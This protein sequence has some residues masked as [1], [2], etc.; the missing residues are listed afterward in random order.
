M[1]T[2][3]SPLVSCFGLAPTT[4]SPSCYSPTCASSVSIS[5]TTAA[6]RCTDGSDEGVHTP[7]YTT[8]TIMIWMIKT[9]PR[10]WSRHQPEGLTAAGIFFPEVPNCWRWVGKLK[11]V[12]GAPDH[13]PADRCPSPAYPFFHIALLT[14]V[15]NDGE[16]DGYVDVVSLGQVWQGEGAP[17][18]SAG[19]R[20]DKGGVRLWCGATDGT[21]QPRP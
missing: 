7:W 14:H 1:L 4:N 21:T 20:G 12:E 8:V 6:K 9:Q 15:Q 18:A 5:L 2:S 11:G 10:I 17:W 16:G 19:V 13:R 3:P